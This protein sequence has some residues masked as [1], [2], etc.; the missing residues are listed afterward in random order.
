MTQIGRIMARA[1]PA[2]TATEAATATDGMT[3]A[4]ARSEA[5]RFAG[6]VLAAWLAVALL[7]AFATWPDPLLRLGDDPD[8]L[9][10]LVQVRD[11]LAGQGMHDLVQRR[12]DPPAGLA[13][14]WSRM[15]D[16]PFAALIASL[17]P[18][19]GQAEALAMTLWPLL[20]LLGFTAAAAW[21]AVSLAGAAAAFPA[22]ILAVL[23]VDPLIHFL[24]GRL[25]HHNAQ[26]ALALLAAGAAANMRRG[27]RFGIA[28]GVASTAMLAIGLETL[29][30]V[31]I[32]GAAVALLWAF[33]RTTGAA[34]AGFGLAFAIGLP[35]FQLVSTPLFAA[36]LCD[37]LSP[38]FVLPGI[39][40]GLGL[41]LLA[42]FAAPAG[43]SVRL[44][45]LLVVAL[46]ALGAMLQ[47]N[48]ACLAGPYADASPALRAR[49]LDTVAEAQGLVAFAYARPAE[50]LGKVCAV[51]LALV[52]GLRLLVR[53]DL[54]PGRRDGILLVAILCA[55]ALLIAFYQIRSAAFANAFALPL[56]AGFVAE[57]RT[58]VAAMPAAG[59]KSGAGAGIMLVAAWLAATQIAWY[60]IGYASLGKSSGGAPMISQDVG[61]G[62]TLPGASGC[63]DLSSAAILAS[64]PAGLVLAPVF[65]GP[66]VLA[67]SAHSVLAGPYHRGGEAILFVIDAFAARPDAARAMIAARG[68]DYVAFCATADDMRFVADEAPDGLLAELASGREMPWLQPVTA[69]E[70]SNLSLYRVVPAAF[71]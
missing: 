49:W 40:A 18:F 55:T 46:L 22:A 65:F 17:A 11:F 2:G 43:P 38:A 16:V 71:P 13:L 31:A 61:A 52:L 29:P 21:L 34:V 50:A 6:P 27:P 60:G 23:A 12:L 9:L 25:D 14:H 39:V 66:T 37:T 28:A 62:S 1:S 70:P 58:R 36:P 42:R 48:P 20:L 10:R 45:A 51:V 4:P 41:A 33:G 57:I 63:L 32:I 44:C 8:S 7:L 67:N 53:R 15:I 30:Y 68:I 59:I 5:P 26:L 19:F 3:A 69:P 47:V 54:D 64:V 35:L 56:L 24:P